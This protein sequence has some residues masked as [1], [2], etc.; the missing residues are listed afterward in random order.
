LIFAMKSKYSDGTE[1]VEVP[2]E[3]KREPK[4]DDAYDGEWCQTLQMSRRNNKRP[5]VIESKESAYKIEKGDSE[6]VI[7]EKLKAKWA[8]VLEYEKE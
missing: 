7:T 1:K 6:K 4:N 8:R 5:V 3:R 2:V